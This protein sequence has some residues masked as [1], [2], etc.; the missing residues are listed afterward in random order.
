MVSL[1]RADRSF[2]VFIQFNRTLQNR[3]DGWAGFLLALQVFRHI[4]SALPGIY[5]LLPGVSYVCTFAL[6]PYLISYSPPLIIGRVRVY[7]SS[8]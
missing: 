1:R 2:D 7:F 6:G 4:S 8:R 3:F 5:Y